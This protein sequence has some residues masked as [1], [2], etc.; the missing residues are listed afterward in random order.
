ML[1]RRLEQCPIC[2]ADVRGRIRCEGCG[3]PLPGIVPRARSLTR[4][5]LVAGL[6]LAWSF[7][8]LQTG[9]LRGALVVPTLLVVVVGLLVLL[10][11]RPC[12]RA[13]QALFARRLTDLGS[14]PQGAAE[15]A[16]RGRVRAVLGFR[17]DDATAAEGRGADVH[18][19]RFVVE[20]EGGEAIVDDDRLHLGPFTYCVRDGDEVE[21]RGPARRIEALESGDYR[22]QKNRWIF[23]GTAES[24]VVVSALRR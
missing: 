20:G 17:V 5:L 12:A 23:D 9:G 18:A 3:E 4:P 1:R 8:R 14:A 11:W 7:Y 10:A 19:G 15:V 2:H 22:G 6:G 21:V 24:P 13:I 16:L